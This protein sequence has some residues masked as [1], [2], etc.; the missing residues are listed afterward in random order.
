MIRVVVKGRV[1]IR[2]A[3]LRGFLRVVV[4]AKGLDVRL[5]FCWS[6]VLRQTTLIREMFLAKLEVREVMFGGGRLS[7]N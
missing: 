7:S 5:S 3:G 4:R 6:W 2:F 1:G